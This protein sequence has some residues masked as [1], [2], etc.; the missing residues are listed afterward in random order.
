MRVDFYHL[1]RDP[2]ERLV[3]VLAQKVLETGGRLMILADE[4]L[5][6]RLSRALWDQ[7]GASFLA[8][9]VA[10]EGKDAHQPILLGEALPPAN[11]ARHLVL[12][13][14]QWREPG[15]DI[16][17]VFLPFGEAAIEGAREAW[18]EL[19]RHESIE[20]HFWQQQDGKWVE[21]P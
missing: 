5:A 15:E 4:A 8:H 7:P 17:R 14:G 13:G 2:V 18:R 11:R 9:E 21:G 12:A 6:K 10:G 16:D 3:P 1:T 19:G 20:R